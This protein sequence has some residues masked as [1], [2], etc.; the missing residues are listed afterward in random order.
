MAS[1]RSS[2]R[3]NRTAFTPSYIANPTKVDSFTPISYTKTFSMESLNPSERVVPKLGELRVNNKKSPFS[4]RITSLLTSLPS[5]GSKAKSKAFMNLASS[6]YAAQSAK[7][8][9]E[10]QAFLNSKSPHAHITKTKT[11][12]NFGK[13]GFRVGS[14][15]PPV[16]V[17]K[18][19]SYDVYEFINRPVYS[20]SSSTAKKDSGRGKLLIAPVETGKTELVSQK[21]AS[22]YT[23]ETTLKKRLSQIRRSGRA[24][25][26]SSGGSKDEP[27]INISSGGA[28]GLN[29]A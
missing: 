17:S 11:S 4:P 23:A 7:Y 18:S 8:E 20:Y 3:T 12:T 10:K 13:S 6:D 9:A 24:S 1:S 22:E 27:T 25:M 21:P 26:P 16:V 15:T 29:F 19:T 28:I 2:T 14:D 5:S